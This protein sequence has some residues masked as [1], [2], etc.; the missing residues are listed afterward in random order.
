[1]SR[2]GSSASQSGVSRTGSAISCTASSASNVQTAFSRTASARS[3]S[4]AP[5]DGDILPSDSSTCTHFPLPSRSSVLTLFLHTRILGVAAHHRDQTPQFSRSM[6]QCCM[7]QCCSTGVNMLHDE[8]GNR[9]LQRLVTPILPLRFS[10]FRS[11]STRIYAHGPS[12][13]D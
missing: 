1:M 4:V 8:Q 9:P 2:T 3:S 7:R 6:R 11:P 5:D 12:G 13:Y 10:T